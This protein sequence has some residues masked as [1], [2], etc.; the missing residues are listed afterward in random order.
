MISL[1][2]VAGVLL[3]P[4]VSGIHSG[5]LKKPVGATTGNLQLHYQERLPPHDSA[6]LA[7]PGEAVAHF[8]LQEGERKTSAAVSPGS[9]VARQE[10]TSRLSVP[11]QV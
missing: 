6:A 1:L 9:R 8:L 2:C 10:Q 4:A 5:V 7:A 3:L 11:E